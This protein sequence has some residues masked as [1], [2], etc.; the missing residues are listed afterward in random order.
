MNDGDAVAAPLDD[1]AFDAGLAACGIAAPDGPVGLAVSGGPDSMA[2]A[3]LAAG[4]GARNAV[5]VR[6]Y[7]VDH[8]LRAQSAEEAR[9][10]KARCAALGLTA[11][12]LTWRG[13]KPVSGV[14]AAAR[15][16]RY[17]LL[18]A[19]ARTDGAGAVLTGHSLDDQAETVFMRLGR[20][21]GPRGLA[22]M[23]ARS[24]IAVGAGP[25][26]ILAR[27]LLAYPR[28]RLEAVVTARGVPVVH[29][30]SN[31]DPAFERVRARALL[32]ALAEQ[33]LLTARG[34]ARVADG[35]RAAAA[36]ENRAIAAAF[37]DAGGVF[38]RWG[39]ATLAASALDAPEAGP[40]IASLAVA[41]GP[42][43][44]PTRE[45]AERAAAALREQGAATLAGVLFTRRGGR[46]VAEREPAAAHG[47]ADG[48]P[49]IAAVSIAPGAARVWDARVIVR[50]ERA[51]AVVA[52]P[53]GQDGPAGRAASPAIRA[54]DGALLAA[55]ALCR[56]AAGVTVSS[57]AA[58]RFEGGVLRFDD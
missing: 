40:L 33:N 43:A 46:I 55:P 38:M 1:A 52:G 30:P 34:L 3:A 8:G 47:R 6:A 35:A 29:D 20:G 54:A 15:A 7:T 37:R 14:Q 19:A 22:A 36:A 49:P 45:A 24:A 16:A 11:R 2:L 18:Y 26:I 32:A 50:N 9:A 42:G 51:A 53:L 44:R 5:A 41:A 4:W 48:A 10:V 39:G 21:A 58:E 31:A 23:A 57:L 25:P 17:R 28:R 27:P 56:A 12:V 13:D